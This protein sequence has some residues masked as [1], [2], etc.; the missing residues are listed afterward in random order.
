MFP[1]V[2]IIILN[3]NGREDTI[4]CLESLK[5]INYPNYEVILVDNGSTDKSPKIFK[6]QYTNILLI[7]NK[8]NLGF[9]EGNNVGIKKAICRNAD[10]ILL[11]NNDTIVDPYFLNELIEVAESDFE[12]GIVGP[13]VYNYGQNNIIQSLGGKILWNKGKTV[14]I[15]GN[16]VEKNDLNGISEVDYICGCAILAKSEVF[17]KI[18]YLNKHFFAYW[19]ETD[20]CVRAKKASYQIL[21]VPTSKIW[22]KGGAT[23]G[24]ISG[25]FEYHMT[26]NMFWFM[27]K[28]ATRKQYLSFILYFSAYQFWF[29]S[30]LCLI[31]YKNIN[32]YMSFLKG[33]KDGLL[34]L[35]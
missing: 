20:W 30:A 18:G 29:S 12:V 31:Y 11:L 22:H 6:E 16:K 24:K 26:R 7:E 2:S 4:E 32:A 14:H 8:T 28:H 10:Y 17:E 21:H 33:I 19:E 34:N 3:W 27:R 35:N 13:T 9:A 5:G 1:K 15:A 25:F 23:S